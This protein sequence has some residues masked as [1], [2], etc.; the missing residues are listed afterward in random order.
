MY[1]KTIARKWTDKDIEELKKLKSENYSIKEIAKKLDRSEVAISIKLKRLNKK[2]N[3]YNIGHIEEKKLINKEFIE[4]LKP[5]NI[6]DLYAGDETI[7]DKKITTSNDIRKEANTDYHKNS[8]KL[9]CELYAQNKKYDYIDLDPF[10]SAYEC[11]DLA[12]KMARKGISI[13]LGE[14]GHKRWKRLDFVKNR[15]NINTMD[16][17]II[18]NIIEEIKKIGI[19][20]KKNLII[21]SYKEWKNI[22]RVWFKIEPY[23]E[24]SQWESK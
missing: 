22:G 4:D 16:E 6:L 18:E 21:Y 7:Y 9:L 8:L 5:K 1:T 19:R 23:K 3:R 13:T 2:N 11:F 12:I 15:Y 10:G 24:L 20:N 14:L 17:F